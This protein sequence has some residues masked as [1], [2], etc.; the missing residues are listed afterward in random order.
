MEWLLEEQGYDTTTAFGGR[1]GLE[2][3]E[4][5]RFDLVLL[6][7]YLPDVGC[8]ALMERMRLSHGEIPCIILK[9]RAPEAADV[10]WA[11][12]RG[13]SDVVC[14]RSHGDAL[15]KI[16]SCLQRKAA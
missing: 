13:A 12:Q 14:K 10:E 4:A 16:D 8:E 3:L 6:D 11:R 1:Q 9:C 2:I 7:D 5:R 15:G